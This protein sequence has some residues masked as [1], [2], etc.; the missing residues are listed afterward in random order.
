M[1]M[2]HAFGT[3]PEDAGSEGAVTPERKWSAV[4]EEFIASWTVIYLSQFFVQ[5]RSAAYAI[6]LCSSLLLLAGSSYPFFPERLKLGLLL[7]LA[8]CGV[9][10]VF[11]VLVQVNKN[12]LVS[13]VTRTTPNQFSLDRGFIMSAIQFAGPLVAIVIGLLGT[14]RF[15]L[16]P[17]LRLLM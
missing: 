15:L 7:A 11:Y 17:I 9:G 16:E 14:F 4:A 12:E 5:L 10:F 2:D 3:G 8:I 1:P 13:R 6:M